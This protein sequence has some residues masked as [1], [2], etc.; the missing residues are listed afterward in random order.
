VP[1]RPGGYTTSVRRRALTRW[2]IAAFIALGV[3]VALI[4][5]VRDLSGGDE[6]TE[7]G[8]APA[9]TSVSQLSDA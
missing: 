2:A 6:V 9:L 3:L 7:E 5:F 1:D 8:T 4:L